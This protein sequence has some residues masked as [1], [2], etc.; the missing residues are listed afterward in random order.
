MDENEWWVFGFD[1]KKLDFDIKSTVRISLILFAAFVETA[2][3]NN[4]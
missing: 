4:N 2:G 1:I 3:A